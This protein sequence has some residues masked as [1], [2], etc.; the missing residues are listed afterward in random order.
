VRFGL[1]LKLTAAFV[2]A[3]LVPVAITAW[4]AREVVG[5]RY[6]REHEQTLAEVEDQVRQELASATRT[7]TRKVGA[8]ARDTDPKIGRVLVEL[9]RGR[10]PA[11]LRRE[12]DEEGPQRMRHL[13]FDVLLITDDE[14]RVLSAGHAPGRVGMKDPLPERLVSERPGEPAY[15]R[16]PVEVR[17]AE[18]LRV[19]RRGTLVV[20]RRVQ[21][22]GTG[23]AVVVVGGLLLERA[24]WERLPRRPGVAYLLREIDGP[25]LR[26]PREGWA[27]WRRFPKRRVTLPG[28]TGAAAAALVMAV[29]DASLRRARQR[30][31]L[32]IMALAGSAFLFVVLVVGALVV[33]RFT[34]RLGSV[35]AAASAVAQGD[36]SVTIPPGPRDEV[37]DLVSSFNQMT[38]EL[39]EARE[40]LVRAERI[41]AWQEIARRIAHEIKNPLTPIQLSIETLRRAHRAGHADFEEILDESTQTILEEVQ[42]LRHIVTEFSQFARMPKPD[43][44]PCDLNDII[45][46]AAALYEGETAGSPRAGHPQAA[47]PQVAGPQAAEAP[48]PV[49]IEL[50]LD[51]DLPL[52]P[53]DR[54][55]LMQVLHNLL[56]N[57]RDAIDAAAAP[58]IRVVS[59]ALRGGAE[60][61]GPEGRDGDADRRREPR[62]G[63]ARDDARRPARRDTASE[64]IPEFR[65]VGFCVEDNGH[66]FDDTIRSQI[67]TPYFTTKAES[68][69]GLG[70][71]IVH[72]IVVEHG[73]AVE[74]AGAPG[75]GASFTVTLPL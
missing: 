75:R 60:A 25:V 28:P 13:G 70:L 41:A 31:D 65:R 50:D 46:Q 52:V 47:G 40:Q 58:R 42:R 71:A 55:Q 26:A 39:S 7:L 30:L 16:L 2:F 66:G 12:L 11:E 37:G 27:R 29:S 15:V 8:I 23:T 33:R 20:A 48:S 45:R 9:A 54:D 72:R 68:G 73:G 19:E 57:A 21:G 35:A 1:W 3:A 14:G 69:T 17:Q 62:Q 59:F 74:V 56:S 63:D 10:L 4:I 32:V 24:L 43:K 51:P 53:A 6:E 61:G 38:R 5:R 22:P 67:F 36:L 64:P 34:G 18:Q 49:D 44:A